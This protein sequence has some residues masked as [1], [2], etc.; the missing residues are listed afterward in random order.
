MNTTNAD[1]QRAFSELL[2]SLT[3][4]ERVTIA[5]DWRRTLTPAKE[6]PRPQHQKFVDTPE[7]RAKARAEFGF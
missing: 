7:A 2:A 5:R 3:A 4:A 6:R 1:V